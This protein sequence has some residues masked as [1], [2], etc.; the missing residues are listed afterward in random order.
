MQDGAS[1]HLLPDGLSKFSWH[2]K[3]NEGRKEGRE[4]GREG[5]REEGRK[6]GVTGNGRGRMMLQSEVKKKT[7]NK[8]LCTKE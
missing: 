8:H 7:T 6:E 3:R 1:T 5:G 4:E 2:W